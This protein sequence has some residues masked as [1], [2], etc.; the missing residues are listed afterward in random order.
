MFRSIKPEDGPFGK[1]STNGLLIRHHFE[2]QGIPV[3]KCPIIEQQQGKLGMMQQILKQLKERE[4]NESDDVEVVEPGPWCYDYKNHRHCHKPTVDRYACK[5]V[6]N[7]CNSGRPYDGIR[8]CLHTECE[9]Q[10]ANKSKLRDHLSRRH[11]RFSRN[12]KTGIPFVHNVCSLCGHEFPQVARKDKQVEH[13]IEEH[14]PF[15]IG[16]EGVPMQQHYLYNG[17]LRQLADYWDG[18]I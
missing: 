15:D 7:G 12:D 9:Y 3:E 1:I 8:L 10:G 17:L 2:N 18:M 4:A 14:K 11:S 6:K 5:K 13:L 16:R